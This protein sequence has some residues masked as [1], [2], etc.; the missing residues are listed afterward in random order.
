MPINNVTQGLLT[1]SLLDC[2]MGFCKVT[3]TFDSMD[4]ILRCD[5]SNESSL[6]VLSNVEL[7]SK[8]AFGHIWH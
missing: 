2:L 3:L 5:H 8:F 6:P 7:W 4:E 1:L